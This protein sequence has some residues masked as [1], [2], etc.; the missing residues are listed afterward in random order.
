MKAIILTIILILI[1]GGAVFWL[2]LPAK[3]Y[4]NISYEINGETVVLVNGKSEIEVAPESAS[5]T[6]T[7]YFDNELRSDFN[8]DG[9]E[10]VAFILTQESGGSGTFYYLAVALKSKD[11][12]KGVNAIFIGDRI[13]PQ[14]VEYKDGYIT[15]Y[16][17]DRKDEEPFTAIP[18]VEEIKYFKVEGLKLIEEAR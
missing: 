6:I 12:Y 2:A 17:L 7:Q 14:D 4:K 1:I 18:T 5:K 13:K 10:D 9:A 8:G 15:V 16:Y 11:T 3:D